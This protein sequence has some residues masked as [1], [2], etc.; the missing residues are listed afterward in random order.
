[1]NGLGTGRRLRSTAVEA[2]TTL[3]LALLLR[4]CAPDL[5]PAPVGG[6]EALLVSGC[7]AA[8]ALC[9]CWWWLVTS[10]VVVQVWRSPAPGPTPGV[11]RAARGALLALCG[12]ALAG[13]TAAPS[14]ASPDALHQ[15]P[16]RPGRSTLQGLPLPDRPL[17][18]PQPHR[19]PAPRPGI[20][21]VAPGDSLWAIAA[22]QLGPDARDAATAAYCGRLYELNRT[23]VG[24]DP[25]LLRPGQRLVLP[26]RPTP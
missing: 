8:L 17:G 7:A 6:F 14:V 18:G 19:S 23:T 5:S 10:V 1:M 22:G 16:D 12:V 4:W 9:G 26:D 2:A 20:V 3:G 21:T 15:D 13:A 11:P 25:D 24:P